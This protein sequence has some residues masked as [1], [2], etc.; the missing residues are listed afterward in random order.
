MNEKQAAA[1]AVKRQKG[2]SPF[3]LRYILSFGI[4]AA[5]VLTLTDYVFNEDVLYPFIAIR[6]VVF[7][8]IGFFVANS[9]WDS[10]E[11]KYLARTQRKPSKKK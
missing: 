11:K 1:W 5:L 4:G 6:F 3:L 2:R 7:G 8:V 10:R 9:L